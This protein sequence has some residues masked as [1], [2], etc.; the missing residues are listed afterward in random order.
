MDLGG[1]LPIM[2]VD[3]GLGRLWCVSVKLRSQAEAIAAQLLFVRDE[4]GEK[5]KRQTTRREELISQI[6][7]RLERE[8]PSAL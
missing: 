5:E 7:K 3:D 1:R 8:D 6:P 2:I 4:A